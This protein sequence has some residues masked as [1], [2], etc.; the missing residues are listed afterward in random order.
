MDET[1]VPSFQHRRQAPPE[2]LI[3]VPLVRLLDHHVRI[4]R[5][6]PLSIVVMVGEMCSQYQKRLKLMT[7]LLGPIELLTGKT[8]PRV[9]RDMWGSELHALRS[10]LVQMMPDPQAILRPGL[11]EPSL[12]TNP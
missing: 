3:C 1:H 4:A 6:I 12:R 10:R 9:P 8:F 5:L 7:A 2:Q 11:S